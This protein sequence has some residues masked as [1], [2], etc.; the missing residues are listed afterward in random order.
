MEGIQTLKTKAFAKW[1]KEEGL[2]DAALAGAV[3]EMQQGLYDANLGGG[4]YKKRLAHDGRGKSGGFRVILAFK[5]N[6]VAI[7]VY[8]FS[9]NERDNITRKQK[10]ALKILVKVY[11]S[12]NEEQLAKAKRVGE[13]IEVV[14]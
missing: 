11:F 7:F 10:E 12:Y 1:A 6:D 9:K 3:H 8:G 13:L 14:S 5:M 2:S 4:V